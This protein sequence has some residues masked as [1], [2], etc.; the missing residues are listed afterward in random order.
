VL[1]AGDLVM[2]AIGAVIGAGIFGA[3]GTAAAGQVDAA[4]NVVRYGAGPALLF[5]FLLLG[6]ACALAALCYAELAAMIPQAGSAYAYSYATL[7]ELVAWIIGWDLILEYAV[8]NVAVAISWGDYFTTLLEGFGINLPVWLT[9]G[10]R[11][12]LLSADPAVHGLLQSA[13]RIA[14]VPILINVPAFAI[15]MVITWLLLRGAKES[16]TANNIMVVIKLLALGLFVGVGSTHINPQNYTPFAPNGFTGIHQG[17]AIVFFAYIGFDAISTA[18]EETRNP[19]RNL[20]LG[21]LGGLAICTLIYVIIGAVLTGMVPYTQLAVADPLAHALQLA[22]F[23]TVGWIVALGAVVSMS[24]VLLVFQYG[25]PRIFFAMARDGLLPQWAARLHPTRR[26]P[27]ATTLVTGIGVGLASLVGDAAETYD[28]T[29]IGTLFAFA[30][31]CIGVLILRVREPDRPRPFR[32]PLVWP[33]ATL[34][35]VACAFIMYGLP[36]QA[37]IRFG[38]WLA[39]GVVIYFAYGFRHSRLK[40]SSWAA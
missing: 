11:T 29:N 27:Y 22:G 17:A 37:W 15:V 16:A 31:V 39:I 40:Q 10:Y 36:T 9:T 8:G 25:Q 2:L 24:A 1:G 18:A 28:L 19:N 20:P 5:S 4:G 38:W 7:G 3:I 14:G 33:V 26:I 12:A 6:G 32:V 30:L 13:P 23:S 21:I 34:G 35:A